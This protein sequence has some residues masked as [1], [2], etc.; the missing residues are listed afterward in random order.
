MAS[1]APL[2]QNSSS[3]ISRAKRM[4]R[5]EISLGAGLVPKDEPYG[6]HPDG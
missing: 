5:K 1:T 3:F 6:R 4:D 2:A